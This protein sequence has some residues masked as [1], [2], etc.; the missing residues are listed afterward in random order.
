MTLGTRRSDSDRT[1]TVLTGTNADRLALDVS[2][3]EQG[4]TFDE[5][6][7]GSYRLYGTDWYSKDTAGAINTAEQTVPPGGDSSRNTTVTERRLTYAHIN[8]A[9]AGT[10]LI[11]ESAVLGNIIINT[12]GTGCVLTVYDGISTGGSVIAIFDCNSLRSVDFDHLAGTGL[13]ITVVVT[14]GTAADITIGY[15]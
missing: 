10:A 15:K 13:Y 3:L 7:G 14:A 6:N 9:T 1:K 4:A 5:D 12:A 2:T 8:A 11:S